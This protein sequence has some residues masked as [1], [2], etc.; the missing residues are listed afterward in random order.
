MLYK[1]KIKENFS[2]AVSSYESVAF[3]QKEAAKVLVELLRDHVKTNIVDILDVGTGTGTVITEL[4][5]FYPT[6]RYIL[7]DISPQ[8]LEAASGVY[9]HF[10]SMAGDAEKLRFEPTDLTISN[11]S[12]QWFTNFEQSVSALWDR[13]NILCFSVPCKGSF[14]EWEKIL[15]ELHLPS[16][17]LHLPTHDELHEFIKELHPVH[18]WY[19]TKIFKASQKSPAAALRYFQALGA[20]TSRREYPISSIR[21]ILTS[22][23]SPFVLTYDLFFALLVKS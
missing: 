4:L 14:S 1:D 23:L 19:K 12:F 17:L 2:K 6:A 3:V 21:K 7:N 10:R 18:L 13:T 9:P 15:H 8:M 5:P 22:S 11:L 20:N 16:P